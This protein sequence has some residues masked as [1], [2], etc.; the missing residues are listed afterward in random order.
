M[1]ETRKYRI[2][3]DR[4]M[5]WYRRFE[6]INSLLFLNLPNHFD[7]GEF[8][9]H[10]LDDIL[11]FFLNCYSVKDW[12]K[13]DDSLD[14]AIRNEVEDYVNRFEC[15]RICADISNGSKHLKRDLDRQREKEFLDFRAIF[16]VSTQDGQIEIEVGS[17]G[18]V[19]NELINRL[20]Y[21]S[22]ENSFS[23][24]SEKLSKVIQVHAFAETE[25]EKYSAFDLATACVN[26]WKLFVEHI[27]KSKPL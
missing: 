15:L 6:E 7:E 19:D 14:R 1:P 27:E 13:N 18:A 5:R 10:A 4:M 26:C 16:W 23:P 24:E 9:L 8:F 12:I 21:R 22:Y 20:S 17:F 25:S 11:A 2:Q 3:Y